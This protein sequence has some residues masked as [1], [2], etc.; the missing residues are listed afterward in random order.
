MHSLFKN[1]HAIIVTV[2]FAVA[3]AGFSTSGA[4]AQAT[5]LLFE[6]RAADNDLTEFFPAEFGFEVR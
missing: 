2:A 4:V 1:I 3:I 6:K 5:K